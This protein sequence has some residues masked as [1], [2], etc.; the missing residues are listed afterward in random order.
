MLL[1]TEAC[2]ENETPSNIESLR[3]TVLTVDLLCDED[4]QE[5]MAD[6]VKKRVRWRGLP[7]APPEWVTGERRKVP[8]LWQPCVHA[9]VMDG[10]LCLR[11]HKADESRVKTMSIF[12]VDAVWN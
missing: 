10:L 12:G 7:D 1:F 4:P 8:R 9:A 3:H 6:N 5:A 2:D 11:D